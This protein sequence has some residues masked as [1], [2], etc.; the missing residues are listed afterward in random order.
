MI[1]FS[2]MRLEATYELR[3]R[4]RMNERH[5]FFLGQFAQ[6]A[7]PLRE[8]SLENQEPSSPVCKCRRL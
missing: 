6:S 5:S 7:A 1:L 3:D 2:H 8:R 4:S